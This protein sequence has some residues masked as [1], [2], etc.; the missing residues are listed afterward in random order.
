MPLQ[1]RVNPFGEICAVDSRG[2]LMGNRG[3]RI[4][5]DDKTLGNRRW[6]SKSWICCVLDFKDRRR[7]VMSIGYTELFFLDEATALAAG[8]RPCFEC[9]RA[10]ARA[11]AE[12]WAQ[13]HGLA[14]TPRAPEMDARLHAERLA[15]RVDAATPLLRDPLRRAPSGAMVALG[16]EAWLLDGDDAVLWRF[17]GYARRESRASLAKRADAARLLT[18]PSICAALAAGYRAHGSPP[19]T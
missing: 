13:G 5:R 8:H 14:A 1:N 4:H 7:T 18:P 17:D 10:D 3:G 11:F 9:R 15:P 16:A 12:A 6:A 2:A 19:V